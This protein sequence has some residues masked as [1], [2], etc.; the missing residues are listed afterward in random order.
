MTKRARTRFYYSGTDTEPHLG[1]RDGRYVDVLRP[2]TED[3]ADIP[4]MYKIRFLDGYETD[5]FGD[6][7]E[8]YDE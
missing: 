6:E 5:A 3:E 4:D 8:G 1:E 7:L 2:L